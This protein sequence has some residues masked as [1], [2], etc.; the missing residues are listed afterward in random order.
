MSVRSRGARVLLALAMFGSAALAQAQ[1]EIQFWH[2]MTGALGDR[3]GNLATRF[4]DSQKDY[5]IV[6]VFKGTYPESMAATVAATRAGNPPHM[7]Q[8]FR[9]SVACRILLSAGDSD[10]TLHHKV[11]DQTCLKM[12]KLE[13]VYFSLVC[14]TI[15]SS[16]LM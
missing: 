2:S 7:V 16:R 11:T 14:W 4:N 5:K 15:C 10:Y 8:V 12:F 9:K 3:V 13:V 6:P 1:V